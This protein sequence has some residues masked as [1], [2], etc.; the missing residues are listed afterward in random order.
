M[1]GKGQRRREKNYNAAHGGSYSRLPPP[2]K[3]NDIDALPSKLRKLLEFTS[4]SSSTKGKALTNVEAKKNNKN[5]D[6]VNTENK[7]NPK[8]ESV[9]K[10]CISKEKG[11]DEKVEL[12]SY[13][14]KKRERKKKYL[15]AKKMK[16]KKAKV[17]VGTEFPE[18][19]HIMFGDVVDAPPKLIALPKAFKKV[20]DASHERLRLQA[21]E[22]YRNRKGWI[23]RPGISL[24]S[25][26]P[27]VSV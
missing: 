10:T 12:D 26:I 15:E 23:S 20:Q 4:T 18:R 14:S 6:A 19:E 2:P 11:N 9:P 5:K 25:I 13:G 17:E 1:G 3:P 24:P 8:D 21:V 16:H 7:S 27:N 22:A